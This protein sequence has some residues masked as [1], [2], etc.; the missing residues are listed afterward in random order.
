MDTKPDAIITL[1]DKARD[2]ICAEWP[3]PQP[4]DKD[5]I[6]AHWSVP[7]PIHA[8][9][10]GLNERLEKFRDARDGIATCIEHLLRAP[11]RTIDDDQAF[12]GLLGEIGERIT[13]EYH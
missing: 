1:C 10:I 11:A 2:E 3:E 13:T 9:V 5:P 7:D 4:G 8:D 12:A 6:F